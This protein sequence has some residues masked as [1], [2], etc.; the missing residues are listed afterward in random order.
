MLNFNLQG[1]I[2]GNV[3]TW[4]FKVKIF[5]CNLAEEGN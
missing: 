2:E 5:K 3:I 4:A 1:S